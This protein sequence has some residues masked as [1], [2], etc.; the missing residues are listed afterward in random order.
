MARVSFMTHKAK[1][2]PPSEFYH[3]IEE[4]HSDVMDLANQHTNVYDDP[5]GLLEESERRL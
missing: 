1:S 4:V 5:D 3:E 2:M